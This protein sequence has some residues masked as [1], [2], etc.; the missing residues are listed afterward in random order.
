MLSRTLI[1]LCARCKCAF[2]AQWRFFSVGCARFGTA[3]LPDFSRS[4]CPESSHNT[5]GLKPVQIWPR[6]WS[7]VAVAT[8]REVHSLGFRLA[9]TSVPQRSRQPLG[10]SGAA[11]FG[12]PRGLAEPFIEALRRRACP[13]TAHDDHVERACA[14][15]RTTPRARCAR[16]A[17]TSQRV[18]ALRLDVAGGAKRSVRAVREGA[19]CR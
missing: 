1:S 5:S 13:P 8:W 14:R 15:A 3:E 6:H 16:E 19:R 12:C 18:S 4:G 2:S 10:S 11:G 9:P 17:A 7:K